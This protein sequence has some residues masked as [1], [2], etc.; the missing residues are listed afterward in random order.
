[1]PA[2]RT[3]YPTD[4]QAQRLVTTCADLCIPLQLEQPWCVVLHIMGG[5]AFA[6]TG[7]RQYFFEN[8]F[9]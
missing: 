7:G 9:P 4:L 6:S 5:S 1:M 2:L 3:T 8:S